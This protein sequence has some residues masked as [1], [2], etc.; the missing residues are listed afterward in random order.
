MFCRR[1]WRRGWIFAGGWKQYER[2]DDWRG[3]VVE[4]FEQNLTAM[5]RAIRAVDVPP[6]SLQSSHEFDG[7]LA[8]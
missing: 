2:D 4:H 5:V 8:I 6:G 7:C 1:M 3:N